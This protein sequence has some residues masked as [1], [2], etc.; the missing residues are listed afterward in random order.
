MDL[1]QRIRALIQL[2][3][4]LGFQGDEIDAYLG[5]NTYKRAKNAGTSTVKE[6]QRILGVPQTGVIDKA[7]KAAGSSSNSD[8][9]NVGF[10]NRG[11]SLLVDQQ[12]DPSL[13]G[14]LGKISLAESAND[15]E[16]VNVNY[17][18][19]KMSGIDPSYKAQQM[20]ID[21]II[22]A[23]QGKNTGAS[24][25]FQNMPQFLRDRAIA[26]GIDPATGKYDENAQKAIAEYLIK[27]NIGITPELM[28]QNPKEVAKKLGGIWAGVPIGEKTV[29]GKKVNIGAYDEPGKNAATQAYSF[30]EL[31][32]EILKAGQRGYI[33]EQNYGILQNLPKDF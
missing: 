22:A 14:I 8:L 18:A 24:G 25:L 33:G 5:P 20:T 6:L 17:V 1:P 31:L 12:R 9:R 2:Q 32:K 11:A 27:Q 23:T 7:T 30:E 29:N 15:P 4:N 26:S 19:Q 3:S 21:E 10:M 28:M 16:A 13:A